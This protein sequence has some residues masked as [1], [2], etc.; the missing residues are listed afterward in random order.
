MK[1]VIKNIFM[2][3]KVLLISPPVFDFYYT[4]ARKE[5]LGLLYIAEALSNIEGLEV[6]LLDALEPYKSKKVQWPEHFNYLKKYYCEDTSP[7]SLFQKYQRFGMSF[8]AIT[9]KTSEFNPDLICITSNFSA[10]HND[11]LRLVQ[12]IRETTSIPIAIGGW[13]IFAMDMTQHKRNENIYYIKGDGEI[14]IPNLVAT[15]MNNSQNNKSNEEYYSKENFFFNHYPKIRGSY[16]FRGMKSARVIFSKGCSFRCSFCSIHKRHSFNQR[17][18]SEIT[19]ELDYLH[20]QG[21][22]LVDIEDDNLF[23]N[24]AW[25]SELLLVLNNFNKKGM[26]FSAMNG[27][28]SS[29]LVPF[30]DEAIESGFIEFNLSLVTTHSTINTSI[31]RNPSLKDITLIAIKSMNKVPVLCFLIAGLP[32]SSPHALLNDILM[33]S[34]LPLIIGYSPLYLLPG[35]EYLEKLKLPENSDFMRGSALHR[36]GNKFTIEDITSLWK[37]VRMINHIKECEDFGKIDQ[38][39][40]YYFKK[41]IEEKNWYHKKKDDTWHKGFVFN[42]N[43]PDSIKIINMKGKE[44]ILELK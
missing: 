3:F 40:M 42:M 30:I 11:V 26:K 23:H 29:N 34:A 19:Q 18:I 6:K 24:K 43:F 12:A 9:K 7:F 15:L 36:F 33:L 20:S 35:V 21:I 17:S 13:A 44:F 8:Q 16:S 37:L 28:T 25:A 38:E 27:I 2:S 14:E 39:T 22:E 31:N 41:S 32:D 5:P 4:P 1:P 10:Y